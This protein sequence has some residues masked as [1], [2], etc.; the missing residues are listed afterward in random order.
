MFSLLHNPYSH[1][2]KNLPLFSLSSCLHFL[3][4]FL[5][6]FFFFSPKKS[7]SQEA[8]LMVTPYSRFL[9]FILL[10]PFV[11]FL[12]LFS[13]I[14]DPKKKRKTSYLSQRRKWEM[15]RKR[16]KKARVCVKFF[17]ISTIC[18]LLSSSSFKCPGK[19]A[20]HRRR[21]R[22]ASLRKKIPDDVMCSNFNLRIG[23]ILS[24]LVPFAPLGV[25]VFHWLLELR[26][27]EENVGLVVRLRALSS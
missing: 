7:R 20:E 26:Y 24:G 14:F 23:K 15:K 22:F 13:L 5:F 6:F 19:T 2:S 9:F 1:P 17:L 16:K 12:F 27:E 21:R 8:T 3:V 18:I 10:F 4:S 11:F 25:E